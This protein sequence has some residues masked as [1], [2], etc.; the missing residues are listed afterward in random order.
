L[1]INISRNRKASGFFVQE[2]G[3]GFC[4]VQFGLNDAELFS[5]E[6]MEKVAAARE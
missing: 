2:T 1:I 3:F 5:A 4:A 6:Q